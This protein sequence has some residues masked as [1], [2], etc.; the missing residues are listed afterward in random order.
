M[1]AEASSCFLSANFGTSSR[2]GAAAGP[3]VLFSVVWLKVV[4]DDKRA[5]FQAPA[6][7]QRAVAYLH[8]PQP[9]AGK[10]REAA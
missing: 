6:N 5:I 9:A 2:T 8:G 3:C 4:S 7:A 10:E 1:V